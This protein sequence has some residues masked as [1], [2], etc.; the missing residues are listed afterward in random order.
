MK[1]AY[2]KKQLLELGFPAAEYHFPK[3]SGEFTGTLIMKKWS[4][5]SGLICYFETE[6]GEKVKLCV[7][8][9]TDPER[10]Y[11]PA[12]SDLDLSMVELGA[13]ICAKYTVTQ[14]GKTRWEQAEIV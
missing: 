10:T 6:Y 2:T 11:R 3:E 14:K 9:R 13:E 5:S 7:W 4:D 12:K 8:F 1:R